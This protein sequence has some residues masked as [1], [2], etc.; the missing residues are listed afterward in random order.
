MSKLKFACVASWVRDF[1]AEKVGAGTKMNKSQ[2]RIGECFIGQ[3]IEAFKGH[4]II[5]F[6]G[7][8][9]EC[10]KTLSIPF[11]SKASSPR[12]KITLPL[13]HDVGLD[14]REYWR[15]ITESI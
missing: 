11:I 4:M 9:S 7:S 13:A 8:R 2:N 6:Y 5:I 1:E 15:L 14:A 10:C 3:H 12:V